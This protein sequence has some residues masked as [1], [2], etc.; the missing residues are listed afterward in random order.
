MV[1]LKRVYKVTA[2]GRAYYYAWR[3]GPRLTGEPGSP[4]FIASLKE[5]HDARLEPDTQRIKGLIA[6]FQASDAWNGRGPKPISDKT[7]ASWKTWLTRIEEEFGALSVKQFDRPALRP[8]IGKWRDKYA[9]TPRAADM[10]LQVLSRLLSFAQAEGLLLNNIVKGGN[11]ERYY[12]NDRGALI[13]TAADLAK[14]EA[15]APREIYQAA[16]LASLTGLRQA[17]VL[18]LS[19]SHIQANRIELVASKSRRNG[20]RGRMVTVPIYPELRTYLATLPK[21]ATTVLVNTRGL[22]WRTGFGSSWGDAC[23]AAGIEEL[24]FHDLRGTAITRFWAAGMSERVIAH[25][26][27]WT[28]DDVKALLDMYVRKDELIEDQIRM[29]SENDSGTGSAKPSA[30]PGEAP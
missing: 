12:R 1:D 17:D 10:G 13:W 8:I 30:K 4:E 29:L 3:G 22:P 14:L 19:W 24:H 21:R 9:A 18:K 7:K 27:G 26:V 16:K 23:E 25:I 20:S 28:E 6:K 5:A 11:I 15:A 2:K